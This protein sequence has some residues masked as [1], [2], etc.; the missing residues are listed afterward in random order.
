MRKNK[1]GLAGRI[2][3]IVPISKKFH[4]IFRFTRRTAEV[5]LGD[6]SRHSF[7]R[8]VLETGPAVSVLPYFYDSGERQ[9]YVVLVRQY[10]P[11]VDAVCLE[12]PG[13]LLKSGKDIRREM[14]RELF[15]EAGI[16][17]PSRNIQL[18]GSQHLANSFCDQVVHLGLLRIPVKSKKELAA[19]LR[20]HNGLMSEKE[21]TEV[22]I[23]PL[24][25]VLED[26]NMITY[27]LTKYQIYDLALRLRGGLIR[28]STQ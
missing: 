27:T 15:E 3:K 17:V 4:K 6:G 19:R 8:H 25:K 13:G 14:I 2:V 11:A 21:F 9:W 1:K 18:V 26:V 23:A 22:T 5:I 10:R 24:K 20:A 12:A 28:T 16:S 7:I